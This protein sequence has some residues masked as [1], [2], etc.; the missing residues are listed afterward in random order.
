MGS[1]FIKSESVKRVVE[2]YIRGGENPRIRKR[3]S[4]FRNVTFNTWFR[5]HVFELCQAL[6]LS[7]K[8]RPWT[9]VFVFVSFLTMYGRLLKARARQ[10]LILASSCWKLSIGWYFQFLPHDRTGYHD[11]SQWTL[12]HLVLEIVCR[13]MRG[14]FFFSKF[15]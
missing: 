11:C 5:D 12:K 8:K 4:S 3:K 9:C 14:N 2:K 1:P 10:G 13:V 7:K 15:S 6:R